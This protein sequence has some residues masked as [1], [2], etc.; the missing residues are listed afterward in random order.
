ML[1]T[2]DHGTVAICSY[3]SDGVWQVKP[4]AMGCDRGSYG[5]EVTERKVTLL[6]GG[7]GLV[8]R[9]ITTVR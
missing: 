3:F 5:R 7:S 9:A 4:S 2:Y 8:S 6:A 1:R